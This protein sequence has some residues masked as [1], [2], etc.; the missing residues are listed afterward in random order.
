MAQFRWYHTKPDTMASNSLDV[1][2]VVVVVVLLSALVA[3]LVEEL[4]SWPLL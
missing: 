4:W 1:V 3:V 2:M